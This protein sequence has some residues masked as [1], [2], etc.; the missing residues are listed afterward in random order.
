MIQLESVR[1]CYGASDVPAIDGIDLS[2]S[3][4]DLMVVAGPSG[5]GKSTLLRTFN[6]LV[7]HFHG[8]SFGGRATVGGNDTIEGRPRDFA[9]MIGFVG[10]D[11]ETNSV[12]DRVED[13]IWFVLENL[14]LTPAL[15][16]KRAEEVLDALGIAHLRSRRLS[17]L[18]GG[19]RQRVA[20]A[21]A[22]AAM[23]R[24]L[25]L[26]EPTSQLDPQSSH[27]VINV[28]L[29]LRDELGMAIVVSEHRLDRIV[30]HADRL[31]LVEDG[32][33]RTG[34]LRSM[35]GELAIGP[36]VM[37]LGR[38]MGWADLPLSIKEAA[39]AISGYPIDPPSPTPHHS[40]GSVLAETEIDEV[41]IGRAVIVQQTCLSVGEGEVVALMGRN[42]SGKTTL[43]KALSGLID[44]DGRRTI[45]GSIAFVPQDPS[46]ILFRPTVGDEIAYTLKAHRLSHRTERVTQIAR[47]FGISHLLGAYPRD[48]SCGQRTK[49]AIAAATA[50]DPAIVI[51][52]EPTRG[53]DEADKRWLIDEIAGWRTRGK[54]VVVATHEVEFA[55]EVATRVALMSQGT[56]V[57]DDT[58]SE[59]L[60]GS[61]TFATQMNKVF[62][63]PG[64]LTLSDAVAA[65]GGKP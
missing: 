61:L 13:D 60:G 27:D 12:M 41:R 9:R 1:F 4:G 44:L 22:M 28:L 20:I 34:E 24:H 64:V 36:P 35:L 18:S 52:D 48:L 46:A 10:Q 33:S 47:S 11:P 30:Q 3:D 58:P 17:T 6:G 62:R 8:G 50:A 45:N 39:R 23:P 29:Q 49:V 26:D 7:P 54:G 25:V 56:V 21:A 31:C 42:G 55:A 5:S 63:H 51:M 15:A 14:D 16:R 32:T 38:V 37:K 40:A 43:L 57:L 19:E 2:V 65:L 53:L 59:V